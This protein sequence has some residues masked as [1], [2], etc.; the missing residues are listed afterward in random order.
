MKNDLIENKKEE[1]MLKKEMT[2]T[3]SIENQNLGVF[4]SIETFEKAQRMANA[5]SK[6]TMIPNEYQ[7][8]IANTLIALDVS[9]RVGL[10]PF[11]VMQN[12]YIVNGRPSWSSKFI[13]ALINQSRRFKSPLQF[14]L[15][16]TDDNM[17]CYCYATTHNNELIKGTTISIKMAKTEGWYQKKGS[18]WQTMPEQMLKYRAASFFGNAYCPDLIMGVSSDDEVRDFISGKPKKSNVPNPFASEE[19][20]VSPENLEEVKEDE[21]NTKEVEFEDNDELMGYLEGVKDEKINK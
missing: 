14:K 18:K 6:S 11:A 17:E 16:G 20:V 19:I 12:L 21:L 9:Y 2:E 7:G 8:N 4:S 5:L 13:I 15:E 1:I 10:A 3:F